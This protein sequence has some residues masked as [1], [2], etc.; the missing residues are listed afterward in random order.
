MQEIILKT[1]YFERELSKSLQKINFIFLSNPVPGNGQNYQKQKKPGTSDQSL[2]RLGSKF[3]KIPLLGMDY[4]TK[5]DI[6]Y[7]V[8]FELFQKLHLQFH[9]SQLMTS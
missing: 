1:R 3:R 2:F 7:K 5:S 8:V 4:L 9:A 6:K